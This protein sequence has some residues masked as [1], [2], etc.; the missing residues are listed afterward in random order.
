MI[1]YVESYMIGGRLHGIADYG[2]TG[3]F[4]HQFIVGQRKRFGLWRG[5]CGCG[6]ADTL[7]DARVQLADYVKQCLAE[8]IVV[9]Q[10]ALRGLEHDQL[11]LIRGGLGKFAV[12]TALSIGAMLTGTGVPDG[13]HVVAAKPAKAAR[14]PRKVAK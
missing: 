4:H 12:T 8:E 13:T 1:D 9:H 10:R 5:G 11:L 6:Q 2:T 7:T 3:D 14:R